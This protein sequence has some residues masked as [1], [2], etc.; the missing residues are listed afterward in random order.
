MIVVRDS[1]LGCGLP[2][3][4]QSRSGHRSRLGLALS[5]ACMRGLRCDDR[6]EG[7]PDGPCLRVGGAARVC[8]LGF[9]EGVLGGACWEGKQL[10]LLESGWFGCGCG[11]ER[12]SWRE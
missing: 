2:C 5:G 10:V 11:G 9:W 6:S 1:V 4:P 7:G 8:V 12:R 3:P